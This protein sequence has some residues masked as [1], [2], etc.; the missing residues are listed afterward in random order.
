MLEVTRTISIPANEIEINA[1]R[2]SGPGGQNVNKVSSAIHLRFDIGA[3]SLPENIREKLLKL[4]DRR[5]NRDGI[6]VIKAQRYR[7]QDKNRK[8]ALDRLQAMILKALHQPKK[9]VPTR[10]GK[11]AK[12]R[13]LDEKARRGKLKVLRGKV[14]GD[15]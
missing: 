14:R 2:A 15:S 5:I 8:D 3:S 9:R 10:P 7:D 12:R 13:R 6:I 1:V 11:A 4:R